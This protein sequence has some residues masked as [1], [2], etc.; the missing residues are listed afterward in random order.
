M[1]EFDLQNPPWATEEYDFKSDNWGDE[2]DRSEWFEEAA[3]YWAGRAAEMDPRLGDINLTL[4]TMDTDDHDDTVR[5]LAF[6]ILAVDPNSYATLNWL[7]ACC[8]KRV[9]D[10]TGYEPE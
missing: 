1:T 4:R 7:A 5:E 6:A 8:A 2:Q 10:L 9:G 3:H